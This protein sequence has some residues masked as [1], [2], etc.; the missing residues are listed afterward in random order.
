MEVL[1]MNGL[2]PGKIAL[3]TGGATGIGRATALAMAREGAKVIVADVQEVNAQETIALVKRAG[4][5]AKFVMCDVSTTIEVQNLI[6]FVVKTFGRLDCAFNNAAIAGPLGG[7][8]DCSEAD[9]D[10]VVAINLKGVWNCLKY[11]IPQMLQQGAGAIV[12]TASVGGKIGLAGLGPYTATKHG[13]IG[14]TKVAA[15]EYSKFGV[16]VNAVCPGV[17]DTPMLKEVIYLAGPAS[18]AQFIAA[19]PIGRKGQPEEIAE[20]VVW[21]CSDRASLVAGEAMSV[22]GGY[23]AQ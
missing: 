3:V 13:I 14:L 8:A 12:N 17:I 1:P 20:A 11:Q 23:V 4:G 10:R 15:V 2:L 6:G 22:D 18:E 16:R 7:L 21:L 9:W 5:E 19:Q